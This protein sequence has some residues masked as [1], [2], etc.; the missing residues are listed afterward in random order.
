MTGGGCMDERSVRWLRSGVTKQWASGGRGTRAF[1]CFGMDL[2][3]L[4]LN[5]ERRPN[6]RAREHA[7]TH[8]LKWE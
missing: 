2:K 8:G 1:F 5:D 7:P 6:N 3:Y 4:N